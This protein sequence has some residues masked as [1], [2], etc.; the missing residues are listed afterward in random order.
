MVFGEKRG[1]MPD[2]EGFCAADARRRSPAF[3]LLRRVLRGEAE[4]RW[5]GGIGG[6]GAEG[7]KGGANAEEAAE[8]RGGVVGG[9][10]DR[11]RYGARLKRSPSRLLMSPSP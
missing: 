2:C 11:G 7:G 4:G 9:D 3:D 5:G 10:R 8:L 6:E 1:E